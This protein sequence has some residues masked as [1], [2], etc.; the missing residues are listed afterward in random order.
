VAAGEACGGRTQQTVARRGATAQRGGMRVGQHQSAS[1]NLSCVALGRGSTIMAVSGRAV[2]LI[3]SSD[4]RLFPVRD[5]PRL[6]PKLAAAIGS[7]AAS[8]RGEI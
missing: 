3:D 8:L 5:R 4:A 2:R 1:I 7:A 6:T